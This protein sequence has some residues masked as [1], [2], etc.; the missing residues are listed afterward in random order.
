M[1]DCPDHS[2]FCPHCQSR[3]DISF[4]EFRFRITAK[5]S[6]CPNCG[7]VT[8][9]HMPSAK[10]KGPSL[11]WS[12]PNLVGTMWRKSTMIETLNARFRHLLVFLI[13]AVFVAAVLRHVLHTY[14]SI[15]REEIRTGALIALP[16]AV[17][18][19]YLTALAI[20]RRR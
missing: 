12:I 14:G 3:V 8:A 20:R 17:L 2:D 5:I 7:I 9:V 10:P 6:T 18:F 13:I 15:S 16:F 19:Y 1:S 11:V 4:M